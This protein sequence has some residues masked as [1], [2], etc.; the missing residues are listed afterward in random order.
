MHAQMGKLKDENYK[1][2]PN[3]NEMK[4]NFSFRNEKYNIKP[5]KLFRWN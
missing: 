5:E 2:D 4:W 3:T 1:N